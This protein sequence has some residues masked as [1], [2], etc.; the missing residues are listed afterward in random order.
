M[1][2]KRWPRWIIPLMISFL[3]GQ[4]MT[5]GS[6][7]QPLAYAAS[8]GNN[9]LPHLRNQLSPADL[10]WNHSLTG[11]RTEYYYENINGIS[12]SL[13]LFRPS[14]AGTL[15][16]PV[17]VYIHGG[18]LYS[19]TAIIGEKSD[20]H[21]FV[22]TRIE[23]NLIAHGI[24]FASINYRLAPEFKW[25]TQLEDAKAA[26]RFLRANA[27]NLG[28]DPTRIAVM[29]DSGG[30]E[31][32]SFVGLSSN[33]SYGVAGPWL[34]VS[35]SVLGVVDMFGPTNR[36][37]FAKKRLMKYGNLNDP[38]Y[39][40]YTPTS[41]YQESAINYVQ[42]GDPPFLIIQGEKDPLVPPSQSI[43]LYHKLRDAGNSVRLILVKNAMHEFYPDGGP[44]HPSLVS[45]S[46]TV[47]SFFENLLLSSIS[48]PSSTH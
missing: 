41:I 37:Y 36:A 31:L 40:L 10:I 3:I 35:S 33:F 26:I 18:G 45:I 4:A 16:L 43:Q 6:D 39:G 24:A 20:A 23:K 17:V 29:G 47:S 1:M 44:I 46:K 25:P 14:S 22:L 19:G 28:I 9:T 2:A 27:A 30:G 21:N 48:T 11:T 15:P 8:V 42:P 5:M 34:G 32:A 7:S 38:V 12:E 13:F